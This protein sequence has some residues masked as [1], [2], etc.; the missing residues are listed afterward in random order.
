MV[1]HIEEEH[2]LMAFENR[3]LREIFGTKRDEI[4][5]D[6]EIQQNEELYVLY[7]S[8]IIIRLLKTEE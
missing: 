5:G 1:A 8:Q 3:L 7:S 2:W 4:T 6:R